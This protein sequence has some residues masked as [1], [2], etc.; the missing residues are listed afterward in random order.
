MRAHTG[1]HANTGVDG[2]GFTYWWFDWV[3]STVEDGLQFGSLLA[4]EG[5]PTI[6]AAAHK[7]VPTA[8]QMSALLQPP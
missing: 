2:S 4:R 5:P 3:D 8:M 7:W 6:P 1:E